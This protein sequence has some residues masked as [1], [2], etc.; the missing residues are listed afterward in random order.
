MIHGCGRD[1]LLRSLV[2]C[3]AFFRLKGL[4]TQ[5]SDLIQQQEALDSCVWL[6]AVL[7]LESYR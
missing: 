3:V 6:I 7:Y 2:R 4:H 1:I 5:R